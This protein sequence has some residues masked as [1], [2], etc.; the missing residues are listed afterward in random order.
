M[1]RLTVIADEALLKI[2]RAEVQAGRASSISAWVA[3]AMRGKAHARAELVAE[4]ED[5]NRADPPSDDAVTLIARSLGRSKSWVAGA[6]G[7][8]VMRTRRAG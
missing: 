5:L 1:R 2:A 3:D 6:L 8:S 4:L 7:L